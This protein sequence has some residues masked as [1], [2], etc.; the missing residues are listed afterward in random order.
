MQEYSW[1]HIKVSGHFSIIYTI[2]GAA[3]LNYNSLFTNFFFALLFRS[4]QVS[5][6]VSHPQLATATRQHSLDSILSFSVVA[7]AMAKREL[8]TTSSYSIQVSTSILDLTQFFNLFRKT[9]LVP[10]Q[11]RQDEVA[12][13]ENGPLEPGLER[14]PNHHLRRLEWLLSTLRRYFHRFEKRSRQIEL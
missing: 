3:D 5:R 11:S 7:R 2:F 12:A 1:N 10:A 9:N 8:L 14:V 4:I 13:A 6:R